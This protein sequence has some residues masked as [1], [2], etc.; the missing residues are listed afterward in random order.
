MREREREREELKYS[1]WVQTFSDVPKEPAQYPHINISFETD[2][3]IL[4]YI[5]F[6]LREAIE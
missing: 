5:S 2:N 3:S 1:N 4:I 6:I